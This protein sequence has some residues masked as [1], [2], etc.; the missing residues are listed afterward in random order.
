MENKRLDFF[1]GALTPTGY[2]GYYSQLVQ[3][4]TNHIV[5]I[6]GCPGTGKSTL[7]K[8][9][10]DF[11]FD[12]G[13][14]VELI[15]CSQDPNSYDSLV[16]KNRKFTITDATPPHA[17]EPEY[18]VAFEQVLPLY[19]CIDAAALQ[20]H[21]KEII[22]L[23][24]KHTFL[25]E[26]ATRYLAAAGSLLQDTARTAQTFTNT[27]K[28]CDFAK[29]LSKKYIPECE[30][31][32]T[33]DD[34]TAPYSTHTFAT[35]Q[36]TKCTKPKPC[37]EDV[38]ILS[39]VTHSGVECYESTILKLAKNIVALEDMYGCASKC[40]LY[41]LR[42]EALAKGHKIITCYCSMSPYDKIEHI[43]IPKLSLAFVTCNSYHLNMFLG[44]DVPKNVNLRRIHSAR[45]CSK[46]GM[47]MRKKRLQ[48]NCKA[49]A[50]LIL[51]AQDLMRQTKQCHDELESY[52][53]KAAEFKALDRAYDKIVEQLEF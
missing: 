20:K 19:Y 6:K 28:A 11:L 8:R 33:A 23:F 51:Q 39:A 16:C 13:E 2:A 22:E 44:V 26:R 27:S 5:L 14:S 24:D 32:K 46:D 3:D 47:N 29:V 53:A 37:N 12:K 35:L 41:V 17:L 9:L 42:Q 52:Y 43:I 40:M 45:F 10:A 49:T 36:S 25:T 21:R 18:P 38:R 31:S 1:L 7:I 34:D 4:T 48:F 50:Q 15:H 30:E